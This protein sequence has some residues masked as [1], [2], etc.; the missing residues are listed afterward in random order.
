MNLHDLKTAHQ[1]DPDFEQLVTVPR[2]QVSRREIKIALLAMGK[3]DAVIAAVPT[4]A[5][6]PDF[7]SVEIQ[8][9]LTQA[10]FTS[11]KTAGVLTQENLDALNALGTE[12]VPRWKALGF[13]EAPHAGDI[14][15][16]LA[17]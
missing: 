10:V 9:P 4:F 12:Q 6:D 14:T 7:A 13:P 5:T 17:L 2:G 1:A 8:S 15:A 16:A 3:L 11:L